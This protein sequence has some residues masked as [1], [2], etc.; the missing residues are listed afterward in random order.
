MRRAVRE[1]VPHG[2]DVFVKD[3]QLIR[4]LNDLKR[5]RH[6][7]NA[8]H[9]RQ[10]T[11]RFRVQRRALVVILLLLDER[12]GL[13]RDLVALDNARTARYTFLRGVILNIPRGG[14]HRLPDT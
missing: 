14:I 7:G 6:V 9:A 2:V 4:L 3:G 10:V 11:L 12:L 1:D 8:R 5:I 13:V